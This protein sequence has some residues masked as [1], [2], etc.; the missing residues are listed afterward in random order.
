M[1]KLPENGAIWGGSVSPEDEVKKVSVS[2]LGFRTWGI[3]DG[4]CLF[5]CASDIVYTE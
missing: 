3:C 2:N 4:V 1:S 5:T